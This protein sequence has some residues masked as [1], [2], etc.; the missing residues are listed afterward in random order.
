MKELKFHGDEGQNGQVPAEHLRSKQVQVGKGLQA[1][2]LVWKNFQKV[3]R[4]L[5]SSPRQ[6]HG[7]KLER[8][9]E[10]GGGEGGERELAFTSGMAFHLLAFYPL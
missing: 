3:P 8:Q 1:Q 5:L 6:T 9:R 7:R 10:R 4:L 2:R